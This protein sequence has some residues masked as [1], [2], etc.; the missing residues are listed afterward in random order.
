MTSEAKNTTARPIGEVAAL[1]F[2][3]PIPNIDVSFEE[4]PSGYS[5]RQSALID[6]FPW[7][8]VWFGRSLMLM[9]SGY[10]LSKAF[11]RAARAAAE[12]PVSFAP[13]LKDSPKDDVPSLLVTFR[14][15]RTGG[16]SLS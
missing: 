12:A 9:V 4:L 11:F 6:C 14:A 10:A 15:F 13:V 7:Y 8:W 1:G 2:A 16:C 3:P 5:P